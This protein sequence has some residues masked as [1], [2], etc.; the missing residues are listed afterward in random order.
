VQDEKQ[1]PS[2]GGVRHKNKKELKYSNNAN[3]WNSCWKKQTK[4]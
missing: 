4:L 2:K 1:F 3:H